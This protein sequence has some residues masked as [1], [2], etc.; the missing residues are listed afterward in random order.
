[1]YKEYK[2]Y[3]LLSRL[4]V[5]KCNNIAKNGVETPPETG[6]EEGNSNGETEAGGQGHPQGI[7]RPRTDSITPETSEKEVESD[8]ENGDSDGEAEDGDNGE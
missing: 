5:T 2:E 3:W 4:L 1:M 6:E 8:G 7:H